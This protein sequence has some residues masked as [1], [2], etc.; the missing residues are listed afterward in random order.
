MGIVLIKVDIASIDIDTDILGIG[1]IK[2]SIAS[3]NI[4]ILGIDSITF[5]IVTDID[6]L[7]IVQIKS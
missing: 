3:I 1:P 7:G 5:N 6:H 4:N 2:V